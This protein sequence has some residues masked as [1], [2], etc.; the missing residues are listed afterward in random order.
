MNDSARRFL[1]LNCVLNGHSLYEA[2]DDTTE[3]A[4]CL[5]VDS[6]TLVLINIQLQN[7]EQNWHILIPTDVRVVLNFMR[8][9]EYAFITPPG[10]NAITIR[11]LAESDRKGEVE[12]D[13]RRVVLSQLIRDV[14]FVNDE[15]ETRISDGTFYLK[16]PCSSYYITS[17]ITQA[18]ELYRDGPRNGTNFIR[19][20]RERFTVEGFRRFTPSNSSAILLGL[21]SAKI[22]PTDYRD[23]TLFIP[24]LLPI[25]KACGCIMVPS[26]T[27]RDSLIWLLDIKDT[28]NCKPVSVDKS[29]IRALLVDNAH[30][31]ENVEY[32]TAAKSS[33]LCVKDGG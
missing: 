19:D 28:D 21:V 25:Y 33:G 14:A 20:N 3:A 31:L 11:D 7:L 1:A 12:D 8:T 15:K 29:A 5:G 26:S 32:N 16:G 6:Q 13:V 2:F 17:V 10:S 30:N 24:D 18:Y 9:A 4:K 27:E 23:T 22:A